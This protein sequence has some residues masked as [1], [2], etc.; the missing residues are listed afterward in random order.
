MIR[1]IYMVQNMIDSHT[2]RYSY[3]SYTEKIITLT[4]KIF[5]CGALQYLCF[6]HMKL[7]YL[8]NS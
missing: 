6:L 8:R 7:S 2:F 4:L 5:A 3:D 1:N